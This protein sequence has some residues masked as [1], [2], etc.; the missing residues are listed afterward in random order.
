[1]GIFSSKPIF[2][3]WASRAERQLPTPSLL[4]HDYQYDGKVLIIGAGAS[5]LAA[6]RILQEHKIG[7]TILEAT[8]RLGGRLKEDTTLANFPVDLGAEWI[9][10][11]PG[12]LDVLSGKPKKHEEIDLVRQWMTD[13]CTWDGGQ[14]IKQDSGFFFPLFHWFMPEYKFQT[15]TWYDFVTK[16]VAA[17][18]V[19][20]HIRFNTPV[21]EIDY[22]G[23]KVVVTT[24]DGQQHEA[25]KVIITASVG[26]LRS[27][28]VRFVP[29][30][31]QDKKDALENM[32]FPKGFK[33]ALKFS[34]KFYP[35]LIVGSVP[36]GKGERGF[37]DMA[38]GK[39]DTADCVVGLLA[40]GVGSEPYY[41][42]SSE[43]AIVKKA[44]QE[45]D[46]MHDGE[47]T[48]SFTGDYRLQDWGNHEFTQGTWIEGFRINKKT[49]GSLTRPLEDKVYFA[50]EA[51]D[52]Y[53]QL[54]VPGAILSGYKAIYDM[55]TPSRT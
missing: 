23:S 47:A 44:L 42:L 21:S 9:H 36:L 5:G 33:L 1:M 53:Q 25:D 46:S 38:F 11:L 32:Y 30:L 24:K 3:Q 2:F 6:A 41:S 35:D 15:S 39:G 8:D 16:H 31:P 14:K 19:E 55:L 29:D 7:F 48:R 40:T 43:E 51:L 37:Y 20:S 22:R 54:G 49:L 28:D 12:I 52:T 34:K 4:E 17:D 26:V 18:H 45:L 27:G 10:N 13:T 50:G